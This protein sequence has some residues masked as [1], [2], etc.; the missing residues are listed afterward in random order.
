MATK[1]SPGEGVR[2]ERVIYSFGYVPESADLREER[3]VGHMT[4]SGRAVVE[5]KCFNTQTPLPKWA[6]SLRL[7]DALLD[8]LRCQESRFACTKKPA[9]PGAKVTKSGRHT[10]FEGVLKGDAVFVITKAIPG[11]PRGTT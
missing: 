3:F 9:L 10:A 5:A 8:D 1:Y 4:N 11:A 7:I 2:G 6:S